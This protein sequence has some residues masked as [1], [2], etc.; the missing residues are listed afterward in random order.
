M[1]KNQFLIGLLLLGTVAISACG[2][3]SETLNDAPKKT[4]LAAPFRFKRS[5]EVKPGL[6]FDVL[7]WGR[8]KDSTSA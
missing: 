7:T 8:G 3:D 5:L 2:S 1:F 4:V 6:I